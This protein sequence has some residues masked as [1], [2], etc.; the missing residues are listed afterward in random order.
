[1]ESCYTNLQKMAM[2]PLV[3]LLPYLMTFLL[4]ASSQNDLQKPP[5]DKNIAQEC[6]CP[7]LMM[8]FPAPA[9]IVIIFL[10]S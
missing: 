5:A 7:K 6:V 4:V 8:S 3:M 2:R 1:M 10:V 9:L